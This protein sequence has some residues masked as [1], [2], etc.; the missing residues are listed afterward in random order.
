MLTVDDALPI[1]DVSARSNELPEHG[2]LG[3]LGLEEQRVGVVAA[4]HQ[5]DP[6][7]GADA[8]HPDH[9]ARRVGE[10]ELLQQMT[11]IRLQGAAVAA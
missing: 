8:A 6:R 5:H 11:T 2:R 3:L 9:F 10:L 7:A 4:E 1:R